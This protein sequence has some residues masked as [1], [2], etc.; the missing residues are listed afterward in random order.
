MNQARKVRRMRPTM[1]AIKSMK[2]A[3]LAL[4]M[5]MALGVKG[6]KEKFILWS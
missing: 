6:R 3:G 5:A 4:R 1:T 2:R